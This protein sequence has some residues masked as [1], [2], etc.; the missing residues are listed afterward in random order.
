MRWGHATERIGSPGEA[1]DEI[2]EAR[3]IAGVA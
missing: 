1:S 3:R 2:Q